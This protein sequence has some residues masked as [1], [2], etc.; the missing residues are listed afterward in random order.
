MFVSQFE[1]FRMSDILKVASFIPVTVRAVQAVI[2]QQKVKGAL[3]EPVYSGAL[4]L[5][6]HAVYNRFSTG[7][8]RF[9]PA[10]YLHKA[11]PA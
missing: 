1:M 5:N 8:D 4:Q 6:F 9:G 11:Q 10:C 3:P 7:G 2:A